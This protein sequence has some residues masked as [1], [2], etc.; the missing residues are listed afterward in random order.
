[1]E[2]RESDDLVRRMQGGDL[3]AFEEFFNRFKRPVYATALAITRDP[4]LA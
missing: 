3:N 1:M 4:F 2:A